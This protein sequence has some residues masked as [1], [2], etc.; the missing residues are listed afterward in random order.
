[1]AKR[2]QGFTLIELL[3]ISIIVGVLATLVAMTFSGVQA[4]NR[5][6][7]RQ[8]SID[9]MQSQLETYYAQYS[10]YPSLAELNSTTWRKANIK[11]LHD[12]DVQDPRWNEKV[13]SCTAQGQPVF[14]TKPT[15]KC[16]SYQATTADGSACSVD[17]TCTQYTLTA[18][19]E[20][21]E[22]YVKSSL[23]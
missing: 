7:N 22:K 18:V 20:G 12:S 8:A 13:K 16:Y 10:K 23:N 14:A 4:K 19:L 3:I 6:A 5:N 21:G 15:E 1:M 9:V 2:E 17:I 11:E